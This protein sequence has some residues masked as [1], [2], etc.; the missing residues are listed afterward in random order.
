MSYCRWS[1]DNWKS[2]V[3]VYA[4]VDGFYSINVAANR[5]VGDTPIVP[6]ITTTPLEEWKIA[7]DEQMKWLDIAK[8]EKID[9]PYAGESFEEWSA[10]EA[11]ERL[12][13]LQELGY[14]V[15]QYAI[16]SIR[17]EIED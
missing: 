8:R 11:V 6:D 4:H 15:P 5:T 3:Y 17:E 14:H 2:D 1:S 7:H 12:V 13:A 16:E 9:L 10:E